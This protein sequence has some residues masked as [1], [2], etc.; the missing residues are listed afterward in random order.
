M[1]LRKV[2]SLLLLFSFLFLSCNNSVLLV[3]DKSLETLEGSFGRARFLSWIKGHPVE[4]RSFSSGEELR[5][6]MNQMDQPVPYSAVILSPL[7]LDH[8]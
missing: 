2:S 3:T 7:Y 5:N 4:Y 6:W 1:G 8:P